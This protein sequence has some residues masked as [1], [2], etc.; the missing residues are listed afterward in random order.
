MAAQVPETPRVR[1]AA[2]I[3]HEGKV[4]LVRHRSGD[5]TYHLL[6]G[7]GVDY[8]E[9]LAQAV[10]R[11]VKEETGLDVRLGAPVLINDTID[12]LGP[13]HT[14][15]ITFLADIVGGEITSHPEDPRVEA[16]DLVSP[17]QLSTLDLRP[18]FAEALIHALS[19]APLETQYLGPLFTPGGQTDRHIT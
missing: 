18:P 7:G 15:N 2:A 11:E 12:P 16:V 3:L 14:V 8:R 17:T 5:S 13:R 10:V 1:V 19:T 4:V 6:P 9:T